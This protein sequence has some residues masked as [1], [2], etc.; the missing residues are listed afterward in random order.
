M[1]STWGPVSAFVLLCITWSSAVSA[2]A[3]ALGL[4]HGTPGWG[5]VA[6]VLMCGPALFAPLLVGSPLAGLR[7]WG[8]GGLLVWLGPLV[9]AMAIYGSAWAAGLALGLVSPAPSV[10]GTSA[11]LP[12]LA[13][14][15]LLGAIGEEIGWRGALQ[16]RLQFLGEVPA[17][18][19]TG[20]AWTGFHLPLAVWFGFPGGEP[21]WAVLC[22]LGISCCL[23]SWVW[24]RANRA[25]GSLWPSIAFHSF[26][27]VAAGYTFAAWFTGDPF[28]LGEDGVLPTISHAVVGLA[29][30][31]ALGPPNPLDPRGHPEAH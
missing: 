6:P 29:V 2:A 11:S 23:E 18:L 15:G 12:L 14:L 28:W 3:S 24:H 9:V 21:R 22:M 13:V 7:S 5:Y 17:A 4:P 30:G 1:T 19:V 26:H 16:P 8:R 31:I 20:L 27:N 10:H 25:A